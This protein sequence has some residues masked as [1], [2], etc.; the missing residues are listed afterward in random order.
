VGG[1]DFSETELPTGFMIRAGN[2]RMYA[3]AQ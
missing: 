1:F 2:G 3:S